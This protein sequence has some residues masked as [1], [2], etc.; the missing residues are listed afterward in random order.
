M[1]TVIIRV[2]NEY[3]RKKL[4]D[5]S[6]GNGWQTQFFNNLLNQFI[7]TAPKEVPITDEEIMTEIKK[8]RQNGSTC[9]F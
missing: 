6:I 3:E 9:H 7:E 1:E 4:I 2:N 5:Y 8:Y